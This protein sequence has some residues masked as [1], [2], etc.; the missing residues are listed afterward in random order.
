[1]GTLL[2]CLSEELVGWTFP[3]VARAFEASA[4]KPEDIRDGSYCRRCG[5]STGPG[6]ATGGGCGTCR[7]GGELSGGI[8]D[9]FVRLGPY[10]DPLRRWVRANKFQ[11]WNDMGLALGQLLATQVMESG[12]VEPASTVVVP[13][14]MPWMRR[15]YRGTDHARDIASGVSS[16][17]RAPLMSMLV[18]GNG[19]PQVSL[20]AS[21][22]R[23]AGSRRL[24]IRRRIGG[25]N[26]TDV[27]VVLVDDVRTTGASLRAAVRQVRMLKPHRIVCAVVA[28]S[29]S[30]ARRSRQHPGE[31]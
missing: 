31:P 15:M 30:A 8:G 26:L 21:E 6:E 17:I 24:R 28:V 4:W 3:P 20:T 22:R 27:D 9:G 14:P 19:P 25:W 29:D 11:R 13:M 12:M 23:R 10:V 16:V 7:E 5:D 1:M 18:R 2:D